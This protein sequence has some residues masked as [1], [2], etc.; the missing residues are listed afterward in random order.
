MYHVKNGT[1]A[2][3]LRLT[4]LVNFKDHHFNS[5]RQYMNFTKKI[6]SNILTVRPSYYDIDINVFCSDGTFTDIDDSWFYN[7]DY[8]IERERGLESTEDH[9][10]PGYFDIEINP[11]EEKVITIISTVEK[12]ITNKDGLDIIKRRKK[13]EKLISNSGYKDELA[14][15]LF[16]SR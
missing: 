6:D 16:S 7:M 12:E 9:Y 11:E 13:T 5:K 15:S 8:A 10:I 2:I 14:K 1:D 4:P 3:K